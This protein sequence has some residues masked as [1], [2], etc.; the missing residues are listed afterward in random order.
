MKTIGFKIEYAKAIGGVEK[1]TKSVAKTDGFL[2]WL[3]TT[4]QVWTPVC[5]IDGRCCTSN[6]KSNK[7]YQKQHENH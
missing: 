6:Q 5:Q 3:L 1:V 4:L 2:T 7:I